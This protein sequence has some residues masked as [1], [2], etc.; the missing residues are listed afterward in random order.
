MAKTLLRIYCEGRKNTVM[1]SCLAG[2]LF[3]CWVRAP[4]CGY[5][6][7]THYRL[8]ITFQQFKHKLPLNI[9]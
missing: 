6:A 8:N 5:L 1:V 7:E 4:L 2:D 3:F 9:F